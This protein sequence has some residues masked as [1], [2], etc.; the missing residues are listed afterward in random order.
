M[1]ENNQHMSD[2][3]EDRGMPQI[4][5][6]R[7]SGLNGALFALAGVVILALIVTIVAVTIQRLTAQHQE[8]SQEAARLQKDKSQAGSQSATDLEGE[9][10]RIVAQERQDNALN[11]ERQANAEAD[12][13]ASAAAAASAATARLTPINMA[14]APNGASGTA[15]NPFGG[16]RS[17]S[18]TLAQRRLGGDVGVLDDD[19]KEAVAGGADG[20]T[21][22]VRQA[23][24]GLVPGSGG[25]AAG[26]SNPLDAQLEGSENS[27]SAVRKA[28][29]LPNLSYLLEKGTMIRCVMGTAVNTTY[30]G[31]TE[32]TVAQDVYSADGHT[33]LI[34]KGA[35]VKGEQRNALTQGQ[36]RIMVLWTRIDDGP[37]KVEF[38]SPVTDS[39]GGS[40]MDAY[41]DNHW[42]ARFAGGTI[43]SLIGDFGSALAN[44]SVGSSGITFSTTASNTD[45]MAAEILKSTVDIPPTAYSLQGQQVNIYVAQDIDFSDVYERV[46]V[47]AAAQ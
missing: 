29:F 36:A 13:A 37:V 42:L 4:A 15:Q 2:A 47:G 6:R 44:K 10:K 19:K 26:K 33:L 21:G 1:S 11:L 32:C 5:G 34:R 43:V 20:V 28:G 7:K 22:M 31:M 12:K 8:A 3:P 35:D 23:A 40:G 46:N 27:K 24:A 9:K 41:V 38:D 30:P 45:S 39:L 25:G 17:P 16:Q 14:G 18:E